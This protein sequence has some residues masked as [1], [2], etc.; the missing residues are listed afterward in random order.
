MKKE[1]K[2]TKILEKTVR[3]ENGKTLKRVQGDME[4]YGHCERMR[5]N[6]AN[7]LARSA[8]KDFSPLTFHLSPKDT[9][10]SHLSQRCAFTLA[11][12]ATQRICTRTKRSEF[13]QVSKTTLLRTVHN[14]RHVA[15]QHNK[16]RAA[17]TLAEVLI[18]LGIIGVVAAMTMPSLIQHYKKQTAETRLK[19]FSSLM[20]QIVSMR[21]KDAIEGKEQLVSLKGLNGNDQEKYFNLY[22]KPYGK[23]AKT[24]K[25]DTAFMAALP[26]GSG[27]YLIKTNSCDST[28]RS[29]GLLYDYCCHY[30]IYCVD[31][32]YCKELKNINSVAS[33]NSVSYGKNTFIFAASSGRPDRTYIVSG[34]SRED[35][36]SLCKSG[37]MIRCTSLLEYDGWKI[38]DDYPIKF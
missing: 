37:D 2:N 20:Q 24:Q 12:G 26:D 27:I 16:R 29:D 25:T 17:F 8:Y 10:T 21:Y 3:R 9:L 6:P 36:I 7:Y 5:S 32:K 34:F 14:P 23:W 28:L 30:M 35:L 15:R 18:T 22:L 11:E 31:Y 38:K 13:V 19:H 4:V 33:L 1:I